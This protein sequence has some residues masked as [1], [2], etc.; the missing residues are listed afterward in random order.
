MPAAPAN[1]CPLPPAG[2][3]VS[4]EG[5]TFLMGSDT[6]YREEAPQ[7]PQT[8]SSFAMEVT[9][10]T[11]AQFADFVA[12]TGYVTSAER[13]PDP[14]LL[15]ASAPA[16]FRKPGAAVF[17]LPKGAGPGHWSYV[18]G[19]SW[20]RPE[21]PGSTIEGKPNEPVVQVSYE[22]AEA[23]A[24]WKGARLPTEAEWEYAARAGRSPT[25]Y[26][27]G[28]DPPTAEVPQA[29]TWQGIFP[30]S[31]T[32]ADGFQGRAPVGCYAPNSW[33]LYDMSGNVWEWTASPY[34]Q[35]AQGPDTVMTIKGGSYLCADN[36]CRR[37]RPPARQGQEASLP[38]N[39]IGFRIV[40]GKAP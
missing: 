39:H 14:A 25:T 19:A 4:I 34:S 7:R 21:G 26:E 18:P 29:N 13:A 33:G 23:F 20:R 27:W 38:S 28:D 35:I 16:R 17:T 3:F 8:V 32:A 22:D 5:G 12:E 24:S 15:P 2:S 37:Y 9:E 11:N 40:M 36:F 10:V 30:I 1:R 6:G 31:D